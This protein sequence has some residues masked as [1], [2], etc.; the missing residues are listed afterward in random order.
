MENK[1]RESPWIF[2]SDKWTIARCEGGGVTIHVLKP[3]MVS[4]CLDL[5]A[6]L[7]RYAGEA[8][9]KAEKIVKEIEK[10]YGGK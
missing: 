1:G 5:A 9:E 6:A 2:S 10:K 4:D 3:L 7:V 8:K